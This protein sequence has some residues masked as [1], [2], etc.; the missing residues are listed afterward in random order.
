MSR[1][2]NWLLLHRRLALWRNSLLQRRLH[3]PRVVNG[4]NRHW[5]CPNIMD[6]FFW[7]FKLWTHVVITGS[8]TCSLCWLSWTPFCS[9]YLFVRLNENVFLIGFQGSHLCT[10]GC[11]APTHQPFWPV[12]LCCRVE[13]QPCYVSSQ[14]PWSSSWAVRTSIPMIECWS[15]RHGKKWSLQEVTL[16]SKS[17]FWTFCIYLSSI[18]RNCPDKVPEVAEIVIMLV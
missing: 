16:F 2:M 8:S 4:R 18:L 3:S 12:P 17:W 15:P 14:W 7:L 1:S 11:L 10:V 13:T 5:S 9:K 6:N